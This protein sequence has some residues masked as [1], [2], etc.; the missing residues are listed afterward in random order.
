[1]TGVLDVGEYIFFLLSAG[2]LRTFLSECQNG[3][4][5]IWSAEF[6]SLKV[7]IIYLSVI[8]D[9]QLKLIR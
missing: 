1:M 4:S 2:A 5:R 7:V 8:Q 3:Y 6:E 9:L